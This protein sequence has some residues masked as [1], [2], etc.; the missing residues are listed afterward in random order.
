VLKLRSIAELRAF[1]GNNECQAILRG[2]NLGKLLHR[3][4]ML[5][6]LGEL[7][8]GRRSG[9]HYSLIYSL[10]SLCC[11]MKT[12]RAVIKRKTHVLWGTRHGLSALAKEGRLQVGLGN[13]GEECSC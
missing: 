5:A 8:A 4:V 6:S 12:L 2:I 11:E 1:E 3:G 9:K 13:E 10:Y 7:Y